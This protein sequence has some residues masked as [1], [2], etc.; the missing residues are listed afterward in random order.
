[1][2]MKVEGGLFSKTYSQH[3]KSISFETPL[4]LKISLSKN[5][6]Q[7][8]SICAMSIQNFFILVGWSWA[9]RMSYSARCYFITLNVNELEFS[10]TTASTKLAV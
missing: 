10:C 3:S 8:D 6:P 5:Q 9:K 2:M 1:M 4:G 7:K